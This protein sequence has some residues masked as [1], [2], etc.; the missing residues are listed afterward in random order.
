MIAQSPA[1]HHIDDHQSIGCCHLSVVVY[2]LG[3]RRI[4]TFDVGGQ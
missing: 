3:W 2:V 4:V 1:I